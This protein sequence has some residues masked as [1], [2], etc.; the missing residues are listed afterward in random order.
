VGRCD[1]E[2]PAVTVP[3]LKLPVI[4][5]IL[6]GLVMSADIVVKSY[7]NLLESDGSGIDLIL[8]VTGTLSS[9]PA[10][11]NIGIFFF[12]IYINPTFYSNPIQYFP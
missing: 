3:G 4:V 6:S 5:L 7:I 2:P 8:T 11:S 1:D 10:L 12:S 9:R